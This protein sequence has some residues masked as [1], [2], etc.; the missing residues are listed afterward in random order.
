MSPDAVKE[1]PQVKEKLSP[2][3][4][5]PSP[6]TCTRKYTLE[7]LIKVEV[8]PRVYAY[9]EDDTY[10][11]DFVMDTLNLPYPGC[12]GVYLAMLDTS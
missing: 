9:P 11:V 10:N 6:A 5:P 8:S 3:K 2:L 7:I 4:T 12:T 1:S